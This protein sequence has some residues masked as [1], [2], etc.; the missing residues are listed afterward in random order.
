MKF[1]DYT[2]DAGQE[3]QRMIV[4]KDRRTR[5]MRKPTQS[6]ANMLAPDGTII[7]IATSI[8]NEGG[9]LMCLPETD[10][11]DLAAGEY[12]FD[13]VSNPRGQSETVAQGTITISTIDRITPLAG[14]LDMLITYRQGTDFRQNYT[15][16]TPD[17]T[18]ILTQDARLIA[19]DDQAAVVL[20]LSWVAAPLD[21]ISIG[22]LDPEKRGYLTPEEGYS[23]QLHISDQAVI[24]PGDYAFD[25]KVQSEDGDWD[26]LAVGTLRVIESITD[27]NA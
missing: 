4:I 26:T 7:P 1:I 6:A 8:T 14:S 21:E 11:A 10:T 12:S 16:S 18:L 23:L 5:R 15:W 9:V 22:A 24:A 3:W 19:E 20:D 2:L 13:V 27:Q 25:M 17:G